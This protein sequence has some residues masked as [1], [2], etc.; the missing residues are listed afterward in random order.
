[1]SPTIIFGKLERVG[2]NKLKHFLDNQ[3]SQF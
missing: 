1:L 2:F 3:K